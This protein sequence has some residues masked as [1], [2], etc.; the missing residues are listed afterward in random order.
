MGLARWCLAVGLQLSDDLVALVRGLGL[1]LGL[2][3]RVRVRVRVKNEGE[4]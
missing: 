4:G 2:R 3:M 1:G